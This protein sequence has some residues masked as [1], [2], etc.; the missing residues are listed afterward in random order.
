[1]SKIP[2]K[3]NAEAALKHFIENGLGY[4]AYKRN[5]DYGYNKNT[6]VSKL[7]PFIRKRILHEKDVI[8]LSLRHFKYQDIEKFIQEVFWRVYW[9]GWLEGR[10]H[11]WND[12][13]ANLET[14]KKDKLNSYLRK[15]YEKALSGKT[16]INCFDSWVNDLLKYGYLHNHARMW[17]AS[18]WIHTLHI[19]WELGAN[20]FFENLFD[21]DPASNTLSWRWVAGLQTQGKAYLAKK[22]NIEKFSH[23]KF[24]SNISL[25]NFPINI[26][27]KSYEFKSP[28]FPEREIKD[29]DYF[30]INEN[31]LIYSEEQIELLKRLQVIL[32]NQENEVSDSSNKKKFNQIAISEYLNYLNDNKITY[33]RFSNLSTLKSVLKKIPTHTIFSN[34]PGIG[35]ELDKFE[36][37]RIDGININY[38]FDD[39]DM[40]CWPHAKSGFF[41][42]KLKI[43]EFIEAFIH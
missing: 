24:D 33:K 21:A 27:F 13:I 4:Y 3:N 43:P 8:K 19:P 9:K 25:A 18:I 28:T 34:Y 30:I 2:N 41:K 38:I 29:N 32:I 20:F 36:S 42:F 22:D 35:Y 23:F 37:Y 1:M 39:F 11:V 31:N 26:D 5:H 12:Y 17:F 40:M 16:G 6:N 14:L 7:S 10:S 15:N